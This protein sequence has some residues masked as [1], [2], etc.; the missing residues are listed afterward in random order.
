VNKHVEFIY[1]DRYC[2]T[3]E[4]GNETV[5]ITVEV[6]LSSWCFDTESASHEMMHALGFNHEHSRIDRDCY[7]WVRQEGKSDIQLQ[8]QENINPNNVN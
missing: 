7:V 5:G 8:Y 3:G 4:R 1:S 6:T 2:D